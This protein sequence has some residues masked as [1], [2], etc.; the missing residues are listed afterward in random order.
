MASKN[1]SSII[2]S[3]CWVQRGYAKAQLEEYEP[4]EAELKKHQKLEK[5]LLKGKKIEDLGAAKKEM[6][7]NLE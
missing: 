5:K 7:A 3:L 4:T 1:S 6:E 2:S